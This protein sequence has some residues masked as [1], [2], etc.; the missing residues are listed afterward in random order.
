MSIQEVPITPTLE[1][2]STNHIVGKTFVNALIPPPHP[3]L[4]NSLLELMRIVLLATIGICM[5][6]PIL[7]LPFLIGRLSLLSLQ[8]IRFWR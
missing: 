1:R 3:P 8:L 2:I 7:L 4:P 5:H 6:L